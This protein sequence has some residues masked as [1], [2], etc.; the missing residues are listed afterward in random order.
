MTD[1]P[2]IFS[3]PMVRAL[4]DGRKTQTRRIMKPQPYS[5]GYGTRPDSYEIT[6]HNDYLPPSAMLWDVKRGGR[7][8][9]TTSDFEGWENDLPWQVGDRL[10][11]RETWGCPEAD[12]PRVPGGRPPR[13][14]DSIRYRADPGSEWQWR[15]GSLPWRPSIHMPRWASRLTLTVTDVRVQRIMNITDEDAKA[16]GIHQLRNGQWHWANDLPE[17]VGEQHD[18]SSPAGAF[19]ELWV[20]INGA[21]SLA[22]N[23]WIVALTFTVERRNIDAKQPMEAAH[24]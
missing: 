23:P 17:N 5:N 15:D 18:Y 2:I 7:R 14:G 8:Q 20:E 16:E 4:L 6:C 21:G 11:V 9:Y 22:L 19:H 10:W 13:G 12:R 24:A 1:R 3:A